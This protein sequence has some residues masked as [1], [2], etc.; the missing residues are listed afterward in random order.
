MGSQPVELNPQ[1]VR[2]KPPFDTRSGSAIGQILAS[3]AVR[4]AL[5]R[6]DADAD[7]VDLTGDPFCDRA[8]IGDDYGL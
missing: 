3:A 6:L 7:S 2:N 1:R 5:F 8:A 4:R